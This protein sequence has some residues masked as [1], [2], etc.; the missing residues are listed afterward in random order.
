MHVFGRYATLTLTHNS[1]LIG[2]IFE[3]GWKNILQGWIND[4]DI[5]EGTPLL[6]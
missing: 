3:L 4:D 1:V 2:R 5:I 6:F